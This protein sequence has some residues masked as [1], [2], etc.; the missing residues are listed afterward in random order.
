MVHIHWGV[1]EIDYTNTSK[2][3]AEYIG[4]VVFDEKFSIYSINA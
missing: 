4:K 1:K 2:W 3:N